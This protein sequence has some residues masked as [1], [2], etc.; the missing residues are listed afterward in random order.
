MHRALVTGA[1][2]FIGRHLVRTLGRRGIEVYTIGRQLRLDGRHI[3]LGGDDW[4]AGTL[5]GILRT[6]D[7]D[8]V[9]HLAGTAVG[10]GEELTRINLGMTEALLDGLASV[11]SRPVLVIAGSAAEYGSA[12]RDGE[13]IE[14]STPCAPCSEYGMSKYAQT[15]AAL[16]YADNTGHPVLVARIFNALGPDM[17]S[18]LAIGDFAKQLASMPRGG[19]TLRVGNLDVRRDM[20]DV[21][22]VATLL[23]RLADHPAARG[24]VNV[25]SGQAPILRALVEMMIVDFGEPVRVEL[26]RARFRE[27]ELATIVGSTKLLSDLGCAPPKTDFPAL[28]S[29]IAEAARF[30][31]RSSHIR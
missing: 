19:G 1:S 5:A 26:D 16:R 21:E 20:I 28:M 6:V 18:H 10:P 23:C 31:S 3:V 2:G 17:P 30:Q 7:P 29:R 15:H 25:C 13:P 4:N 9:F 24:I 8:C 14:E 11:H 12:I 27:K 22:H